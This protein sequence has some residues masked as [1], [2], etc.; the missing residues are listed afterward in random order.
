MNEA[1]YLGD[2]I[3]IMKNGVLKA[4]GSSLYLKSIFGKEYDLI[5]IKDKNFN[6]NN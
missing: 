5:F 2:R 6:K 1:D 3:G 4:C